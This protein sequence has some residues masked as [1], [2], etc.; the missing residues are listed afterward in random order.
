MEWVD[1][2]IYSK[3]EYHARKGFVMH[4]PYNSGAVINISHNI[5]AIYESD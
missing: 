2:Q 3:Y 5:Y 1:T 4:M